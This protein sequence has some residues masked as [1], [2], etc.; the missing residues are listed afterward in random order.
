MGADLRT[1]AQSP[2]ECNTALSTPFLNKDF[3]E[4]HVG[5][6]QRDVETAATM[7]T[8]GNIVP[9]HIGDRKGTLP[10]EEEQHK[11]EAGALHKPKLDL[12]KGWSIE[13]RSCS[14]RSGVWQ[15]LPSYLPG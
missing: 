14:V 8:V 13:R 10:P 7:Y 11:L 5:G 2:E 12:T 3:G 1:E 15:L 6:K 4:E 9:M